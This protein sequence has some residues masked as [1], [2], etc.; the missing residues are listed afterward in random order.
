MKEGR[1][2]R[3]TYRGGAHLKRRHKKS[4]VSVSKVWLMPT[5]TTQLSG[6][7]ILGRR[8][9]EGHSAI[10]VKINDHCLEHGQKQPLR[11]EGKENMISQ[12]CFYIQIIPLSYL[13]GYILG[14]NIRD[15]S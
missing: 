13:K 9:Q 15:G 10:I 3:S 2:H 4:D 1:T 11:S 12:K 14:R 8:S 6:D 7:C 5:I